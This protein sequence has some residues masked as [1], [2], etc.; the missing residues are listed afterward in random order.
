MT[1]SSLSSESRAAQGARSFYA[2]LGAI[3]LA[4]APVVGLLAA[5]GRPWEE[6]HP[7]I[8]ALLNAASTVFLLAGYLAIRRRN[9]ELHWRSMVGAFTASAVFLA[10]YLARFCIS[11][12]HRYPGTGADKAIYLII[13]F[14]HMLLALVALPMILR[15]F[16][17]ARRKRWPNHRRLARWA[18][19]VWVY[20]SITGVVVYLMLYPLADALYRS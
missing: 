5:S 4:C 6:V 8:N 7:A 19:P 2:L 20:V 17:L 16:W 14:S 11:G 15:M 1:T 3:G 9:V 18:W 13:L 10:S 12:T